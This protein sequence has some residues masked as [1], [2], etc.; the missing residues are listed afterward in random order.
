MNYKIFYQPQLEQDL[1]NVCPFI[2]AAEATTEEPNEHWENGYKWLEQDLSPEEF[3]IV[4]TAA[5]QFVAIDVKPSPA[6]TGS[7][8]GR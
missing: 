4:D 2:N 3:T 6:P 5:N 8:T 1:L 7:P